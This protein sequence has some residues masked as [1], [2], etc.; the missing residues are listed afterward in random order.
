MLNRSE[1]RIREAL[2]KYENDIANL[3]SNSPF[4]KGNPTN[5][6]EFFSENSAD[7]QN[8]VGL[9]CLTILY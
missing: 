6:P 3:L 1:G 2:Q 8:H 5:R 4:D 9:V 7:P